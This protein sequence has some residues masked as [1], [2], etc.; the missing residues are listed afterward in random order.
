MSILETVKQYVKKTIRFLTTLPDI[1]NKAIKS[2]KP[3]LRNIPHTGKQV[4]SN[5]KRFFLRI[6][7]IY[8]NT[9]A[10]AKKI[11]IAIPHILKKL[12]SDIIL[13]FIYIPIISA[14][15]LLVI[16]MISYPGFVTYR[17][18]ASLAPFP[19]WL[20]FSVGNDRRFHIRPAISRW[21]HLGFGIAFLSLAMSILL[22]EYLL[23]IAFS[24]GWVCMIIATYRKKRLFKKMIGTLS[25]R[26]SRLTTDATPILFRHIVDIL[27]LYL[28]AVVAYAYTYGYFFYIVTAAWLPFLAFFYLF[29]AG[30]LSGVVYP[31]FIHP[32]I[33]HNRR[34]T[35]QV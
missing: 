1:C 25:S 6:P 31:L 15:I 29:F 5:T 20:L 22:K 12:V 13:L 34:Y 27:S 24:S 19:F 28:I 9:V 17:L 4:V 26:G 35:Q 14:A 10:A 33:A 3:L 30:F 18:Y 32:T 23:G 11:R 16:T 2:A 8:R 7:S 21:V